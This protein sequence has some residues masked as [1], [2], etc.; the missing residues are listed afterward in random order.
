MTILFE[1]PRTKPVTA[2]WDAEMLPLC[3]ATA[4][5]KKLMNFKTSLTPC[6]GRS[7]WQFRWC[8][9]ARTWTRRRGCVGAATTLRTTASRWPG[10][11]SLTR[12]PWTEEHWRAWKVDQSLGISFNHSRDVLSS[13]L[14]NFC[15][16]VATS[17]AKIFQ[18]W[19]ISYKLGR[20]PGN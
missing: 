7:V 13:N 4:M 3:F 16:V 20:Q 10:S 12:S 9:R 15:P 5:E 6:P 1:T 17:F 18:L 11:S 14:I 8:W 2:G 19:A